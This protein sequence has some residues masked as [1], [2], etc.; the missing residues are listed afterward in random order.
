MRIPLFLTGL[1]LAAAGAWSAAADDKPPAPAARDVQ[2]FVVLTEKRPVLIRLHVRIEGKPLQTA[3]ED[4]VGSVFKS[5]DRDGDGALSAA[6]AGRTPPA[7]VLFSNGVPGNA[8]HPTMAALDADKDGKVTLDELKAYYRREAPP[9]QFQV[10]TGPPPAQPGVMAQNQPVPPPSPEAVTDALFALLDTNK[11]GKL[12]KEEL[13]AAPSVLL[14]LDVND[15]EMVSVD[16]IMAASDG[17]RRTAASR[18]GAGLPPV[19]LVTTDE[20]NADLAGKL[21]ARYARPRAA[22][23]KK[24]SREDLGLDEATFKRL[25]ANDD[26]VLDAEELAGFA[27]RD[28]DVELAVRLAGRAG[29][30]G[31]KPVEILTGK[32]QP[33]PL[34]GALHPFAEGISLDL[35]TTRLDLV[36][37]RPPGGVTVAPPQVRQFFRAQFSGADKGNKGHLDKREADG[38]PSFRGLFAVMDRDGDG[39]LTEREVL[40]YLDQI[41]EYQARARAGCVLMTCGDQGGGL[42]DL[43]DTNRDGRLSVREMRQAVKLLE[44]LDRDGDAQLAR[45]EIPRCFRLSLAQ[46]PVVNNPLP[47]NLAVMARAARPA[48]PPRPVTAGPLWFRKMDRNGDG[49]VSRREFPGTDEE[50][51][52]IDT[53]GDGLI[54]RD[55]AERYDARMRKK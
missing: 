35:G 55:E 38:V 6:E 53:D 41:Q 36:V 24:L 15:D 48:P 14:K 40:G 11:D 10:Y 43:L 27:R 20:P 33:S 16:E 18:T 1:A 8:P 32:D 51:A 25:D 30:G 37:G 54:S 26:G 44:A 31:G 29:P 12:S 9:F 50:F 19:V 39:K 3:W 7:S 46:G 47:P 21:L 17:P 49:D 2:D 45:S 52:A 22:E 5:L 4:F 28:P 23:G 34:A 13:A 42:F